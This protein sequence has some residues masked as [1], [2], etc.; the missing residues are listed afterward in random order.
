MIEI[1]DLPDSNIVGLKLG[2][3][4][5]EDDYEVFASHLRS[6]LETHTT[7]RVLLEIEDVEAW[8][9][10]DQ[11]ENLTFRTWTRSP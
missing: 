9:P 11:W 10:E 8:E 7:A 1:L 4:L 5:S 6:E 2:D 3:T